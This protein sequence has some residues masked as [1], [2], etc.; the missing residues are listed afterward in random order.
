MKSYG[1][2][3]MHFSTAMRTTGMERSADRIH[4]S[5]RASRHLTCAMHVSQ[6]DVSKKYYLKMKKGEKK[7]ARKPR[8]YAGWTWK[9]D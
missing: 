8:S 2:K 6:Y 7:Q 5:A 4:K 3:Q 9:Y 1:N